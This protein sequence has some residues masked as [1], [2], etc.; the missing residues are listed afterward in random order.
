MRIFSA[1]P[2]KASENDVFDCDSVTV[3]VEETLAELSELCLTVFPL[4][5]HD[6]GQCYINQI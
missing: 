2:E 3:H 1:K 6:F 4:L 5:F